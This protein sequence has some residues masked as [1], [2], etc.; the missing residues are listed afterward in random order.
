[1]CGNID[2]KGDRRYHLKIDKLTRANIMIVAAVCLRGLLYGSLMGQLLFGNGERTG[3]VPK[4][5]GDIDKR[6]ETQK[7]GKETD[8][9]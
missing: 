4:Q 5:S 3:L 6:A 9:R 7:P 2:N 1:M 8:E